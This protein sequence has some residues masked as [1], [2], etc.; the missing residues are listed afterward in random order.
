MTREDL[1]LR[2][3]AI[4]QHMPAEVEALTRRDGDLQPI[5]L[6]SYAEGETRTLSE[7]LGKAVLLERDGQL[8]A[9]TAR[10]SLVRVLVARVEDHLRN[11]Y[12]L[13]DAA[14]FV[15]NAAELLE[16][17]TEE[18]ALAI[19]EEIAL[20]VGRIS[21]WLDVLLPWNELNGTMV[22]ELEGGFGEALASM[23]GPASSRDDG[24][25]P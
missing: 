11:W 5:G 8:E 4:W 2:G 15:A 24:V 14:A 1:R 7:V 19:V 3:R 22:R 12:G 21:M 16:H 25:R 18:E 13:R 10:G 20:Y 17:A 9:G 23:V 6:V